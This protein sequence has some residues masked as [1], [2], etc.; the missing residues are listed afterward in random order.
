MATD[1]STSQIDW[2]FCRAQSLEYDL[3]SRFIKQYF[4]KL[5]KWVSNWK[6]SNRCKKRSSQS[7]VL[8]HSDLIPIRFID[9]W[10]DP[11]I[12]FSVFNDPI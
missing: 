1:T 4:Y 9:R 11:D 10:F 12:L 2:S 3:I 6:H 8:F 5:W 7:F